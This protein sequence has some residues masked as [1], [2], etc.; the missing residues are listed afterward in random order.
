[1]MAVVI[2]F[3]FLVVFLVQ[4]QFNPNLPNCHAMSPAG[5]YFDWSSVTQVFSDNYHRAAVCILD[6]LDIL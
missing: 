6:I 1:M 2:Y 4:G 3:S 5:D